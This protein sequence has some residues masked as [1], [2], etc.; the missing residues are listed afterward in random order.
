MGILRQARFEYSIFFLEVPRFPEDP[1]LT[2]V[3]SLHYILGEWPRLPFTARIERAPFHRARSASKKEKGTW[4]LPS[5]PSQAARCASTEDHQPPSPLL[6]CG[7]EG[8]RA[9]PS[10]AGMRFQHPPNQARFLDNCSAYLL[11]LIPRRAPLAR[12][13]S[14]NRFTATLSPFSEK[15][16]WSPVSGSKNPT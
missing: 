3:N 5:D 10:P 9:A 13:L 12:D 8:H 1:L 7:Q 16:S 11:Y 14:F 15:V 6:F 2:I 4:P